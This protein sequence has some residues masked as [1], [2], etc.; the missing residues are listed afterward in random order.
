MIDPT[1]QVHPNAE[2]ADDV[3]VGA[4]SI[5]GDNV[6]IGAGCEIGSHVVIKGHTKMGKQNKIYQFCSIGE[7][8]Q[9]LGYA[10]EKTWLELGNGNTIRE[11]CTL[12]RGSHIGSGKTV[13]GHNNFIMAYV[14]V[15][16]D[17]ILGNNIVMANGSTLAGHVDIGDHAI[18]GGYTMVHQFCR[19]GAHCITGIN[20]ICT[21]DIAPFIL[22]AGHPLAP[23]GLNVKGLRR[24]D[25]DDTRIAPLKNA[26]RI[27]FRSGDAH[28]LTLEKLRALEPQSHDIET[29]LAFLTS[30]KRGV[31]R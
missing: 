12:N 5:I 2:L 16:H 20:A 23:H 28:A 15:A 10:G 27:Y 4:Y 17:C 7:D 25:F 6:T 24:R 21:K 14:H 29:L 31:L 22:V 19:L 9:F 3:I 26:Y 11:F 8:P 18:L 13:V 30:S 1:A